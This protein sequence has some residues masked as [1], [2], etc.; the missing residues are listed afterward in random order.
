M[1]Y[2]ALNSLSVLMCHKETTYSLTVIAQCWYVNGSDLTT[3][4]SDDNMTIEGLRER[5]EYVRQLRN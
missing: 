3:A 5:T 1:P 4:R 2:M